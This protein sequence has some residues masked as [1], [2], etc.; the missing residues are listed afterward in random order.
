MMVVGSMQARVNKAKLLDAMGI[1]FARCFILD[2]N[3]ILFYFYG[4]LA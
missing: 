1:F 2:T 4:L 3:V